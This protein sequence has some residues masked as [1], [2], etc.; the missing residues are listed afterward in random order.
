METS[1]LPLLPLESK[2]ETLEILRK[3]SEARQALGKLNGVIKIVPNEAILLNLLPLQEAKYSSEIENIITTHDDIFK[4]QIQPSLNTNAKEVQNYARALV[5]GFEI[6]KKKQ[7]L[8]NRTILEIQKIILEN[9]AGFRKQSGTV[10]KNN[11]GEIVYTPPQS[12]EEIQKLMTNLEKF[13]NEKQD[14]EKYKI[15]P[16]VKMAI[17]HHQFESIHP[18]YDGNGRAGRIINILYLCLYDILDL[19]ILYLSRY[20]IDNK[21]VYY[22]LLQE[23]R[24]KENWGEWVLFF[25]QGIIATAEESIVFIN[26][27]VNLMKHFKLKIKEKYPKI[28]SQDLINSLFKYPYTKIDFIVEDLTVSRQ[29]ASKYLEALVCDEEKFLVKRKIGRNNYY[30]NQKLIDAASSHR[31]NLLKKRKSRKTSY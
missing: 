14:V 9:D 29:T 20:I 4:N 1:E 11:S 17:I 16:L 6:V 27:I 23:V 2:V 30:I 5:E 21:D 7:L 3:S 19:P 22:R 18:F 10:L 8:N 25:I 24:I 28:Y 31:E 26:T 15:D 12:K 13:I